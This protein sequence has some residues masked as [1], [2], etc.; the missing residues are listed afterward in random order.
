MLNNELLAARKGKLSLSQK[1]ALL[2]KFKSTS[3][4]TTS[5]STIL[6][7][8]ITRLGRT[9]APL[10]AAQQRLWFEW[11]LNP[12]N[13]AYHLGG[14]MVLKGKLETNVLAQSLRHLV[15]RHQALR[16]QFIEAEN[17]LPKQYI[18]PD[19]LIPLEHITQNE[20][21]KTTK[22]KGLNQTQLQQTLLDDFAQ[23]GFDLRKGPLLRV[24]CISFNE[25]AHLLVVVM[26][27][28]ISDAWSKELIVKDFV[29]F[30]QSLIKGEI[31]EHNEQAL[32]YTDFAQ[33]QID[34]LQSEAKEV[35]QQWQFWQQE[36]SGQLPII[37]LGKPLD[38]TTKP[39]SG[40]ILLDNISTAF[41][42]Q[43]SQFSRS[44][45]VTVFTVL[46]TAYQ[47]LLHRL[48]GL[49]TLLTAIPVANRNH[50]DTHD[51]VGFF[52][53]VQLLHLE[54]SA[55]D[56]LMQLLQR[57]SDKTL[58]MQANQ[59]IPIDSLIKCFQE[60]FQGS[61]G[62]QVMFNHLKENNEQL[63]Q[64]SGLALT[65]YLTLTQGVMCDLALDTTELTN[66][67]INLQWSYDESRLT[68]VQVARFNQHY[69]AVLQQLVN[70][71]DMPIREIP[72]LTHN[73]QQQLLN[74]GQGTNSEKPILLQQCFS[75]QAL[76]TP[77][78]K[79]LKIAGK[80]LTYQQ[81]NEQVNRLTHYF[82]TQ[83]VGLESRVGIML[84]RS[85]DMVITMLAILKAG[86]A[87][88]PFDP[89]Y[90]KQRLDFIWQHSDCV[91]LCSH[92][93]LAK[94]I[95]ASAQAE[96]I[97][98]ETLDTHLY[99]SDEPAVTVRPDNLAYIIYTSG[100]TGQPKGVACNHLGVA[101]RLAWG[102][103]NYPITA[104]DRI[105]Q[106]TSFGFDVS[107]WEFFWPLTQG[108]QL[109]LAAPEQ[110]KDP[111]QIQTLIEQEQITVVH[112]V[113]SMLQTFLLSADAASCLSLRQVFTSGEAL[114]KETQN[115]LLVA[116]P[117]VALRNL[118]G[119]TETAI[120][121]TYWNCQLDNNTQ[122]PIGVPIA[123]VQAYVVDGNLNLVAPGRAGELLL[124]GRCLARGYL[125]R[126]DLTAD[127]FIA[128][129]FVTTGE[130][131]YR[132]GD[133][134]AWSEAGQINY[135]G[136]I[137]QQIKIRGFRI[138]LGE[139]E[140]Q[141]LAQSSVQEAAVLAK[142]AVGGDQLVAYVVGIN[143][144][145]QVLQQTL[146]TVLPDYMVPSLIIILPAMPL[147]ANGKLDR[148]ALPAPQWQSTISY[149]A[150]AGEFERQLADIWQQ[151]LQVDQVGRGDNFFSLGGHSLLAVTVLNQIQQ[152]WLV[153][154]TISDLFQK[155][156]LQA[157]AQ[158][159]GEQIKP[160]SQE[161]LLDL[162]A[163]M[164]T[165][166]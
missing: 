19:M 57:C 138:E 117:Q 106:K 80:S 42:A 153:E 146:T 68:Q 30:Y 131:L 50:Y 125:Q 14:A 12:K 78:A 84:E 95:P 122:V 54:I 75:Q 94:H 43:I 13:A 150:P 73:E 157:L 63:Q 61:A 100:S 137:D 71:A 128:N 130:R 109:I 74:W 156:T 56:T 124:G 25:Q 49:E 15:Q 103:T 91:L 67:T 29:G 140:A 39:A 160:N 86:A 1:K 102:Q 26:H 16:S 27:H 79:A 108:A 69:Q 97:Y 90:P 24:K 76:K 47:V 35:Q 48:T 154:L 41:S 141:L 132:T 116:L 135:L 152:Q 62:Y 8:V 105:L 72:L 10:S 9:S 53:N 17:G 52:V 133:L 11:L 66:G 77:R 98:L 162:E 34:W 158:F 31:P 28:I 7:P 4:N 110:H 59:D 37:N 118:Y 147:T 33:W 143:I 111:Q 5:T 136:R 6:A 64:L 38:H 120:E 65:E 51:I 23:A 101:N 107:I 81:L 89:T 139:I 87:Y 148:K 3:T 165:L 126:A 119:P 60:N 164:E 112:F 159:I 93:T 104:A 46:L 44:Q 22:Y 2:D 21:I 58:A 88:V 144:D 145:E 129:P 32:Q 134:V 82:Q 151:V 55:A 45:G 99:S 161:T 113:P 163:F 70:Q 115:Q 20:L 96:T 18:L 142:K 149:I 123:G 166:V 92:Q 155:Q 127:R 114:S 121:V 36:L 83:G 85:F 40:D